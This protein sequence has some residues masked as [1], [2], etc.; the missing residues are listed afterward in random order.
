MTLNELKNDVAQLGFESGIDDEDCLIASANRALSLIYVDRPVS[1]TVSVTLRSPRISLAKSFIEH[2]SG[3]VITIQARGKAISFHSSGNGVC[4]IKDNTGSNR[5]PLLYENQL[6]KQKLHGESTITFSGDYYYTV[7]DLAVYEDLIS[8]LVTDIPEYMPYNELCP[9]DYCDDFRAFSGYPR[10][11]DGKEIK[12]LELV[13]GKIRAPLDQR[14]EIYLTYYRTPRAIEPEKP[15]QLIDVSREC[16]PLLSLL[17]ASF[18]W[19]DDDAGK[20][21]YY[22]SLYRDIIAGVKR[23]SSNKIDTAYSHNG[24][25]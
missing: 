24:W 2:L 8:D 21:Q 7:S 6:T 16:E 5:V 15:N 11:K 12:G 23:Y 4:V 18:M 22:M 10:D 9:E 20:A 17:T 19:L 3:E 13:D 14:G 1:K 25:A